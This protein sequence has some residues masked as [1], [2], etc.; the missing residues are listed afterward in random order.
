MAN[1]FLP[2]QSQPQPNR[3][4]LFDDPYAPLRLPPLAQISEF[5]RRYDRLADIH[6]KKLTTNL[7][8]NLDVLLIFA[9]L[10]SAI[11]TTFISIT[12]PDLSPNPS[13]ETNALLRLLVTRADNN[14][15]TQSDFAPPFSAN[16]NSITV[17]CLLY[18]SLSCSLL[19]AV[20]AMMA[21]E[22]LQSFDRTGQTGPLEDQARFRQR[23]YNGVQEWHLEAV[24]KFLPNLLLLSVIFF[25]VGICL[26]LFPIN[27]IVAG[28][29]I[30][31]SGIG[32]V[33]SGIVIVAG[34]VSLTCPYQSAASNALRRGCRGLVQP[35]RLVWRALIRPAV[36]RTSEEL[37]KVRTNM[38]LWI[39]FL[40]AK[41]TSV[42]LRVRSWY[43]RSLG[44]DHS[45]G[46]EIIDQAPARSP[47]FVSHL[48]GS[49]R[50]YFSA[51]LPVN[52]D[53]EQAENQDSSNEAERRTI[54]GGVS[55]A[56]ARV[57]RLWEMLPKMGFPS[58]LHQDLAV[59]PMK[60]NGDQVLT[61]QAA[62]WLLE[63]TSNRGDQ[64]STGQFICS[65]DK[66]TCANIFEEHDSWNR[67]F[68]LTLGSF[69]IWYS[70]PNKENQEVAELFG[71]V[72]CRVL[73]QC[74]KEDAKWSDITGNSLQGS[75]DF[76]KTFLHTLVPASTRYWPDDPEDD[77][78]ILY[79]SLMFTALKEGLTLKEFQ[80]A[81][82]S[83]LLD[84]D[85]PAAAALLRVWTLIVW[86]VGAA[87][88][89]MPV[90]MYFDFTGFL[91]NEGELAK[92]LSG[93]LSESP[94]CFQLVQGDL[95]SGQHAAQGY[96]VCLQKARQL[97]PKPVLLEWKGIDGLGQLIWSYIDQLA[98]SGSTEIRF[99]K[100]SVEA[101]LT[102]RTSLSSGPSSSGT[103][104]T[105][106]NELISSAALID[107][108]ADVLI[109]ELTSLTS[110]D[111]AWKSKGRTF[112]ACI[113][114]MLL[115]IWRNHPDR[116]PWRWERREFFAS[117]CRLWAPLEKEVSFSKT[118]S[119][120][121]E[122]KP[123][124]PDD[125][126]GVAEFAQW[127][128]TQNREPY[129]NKDWELE[130]IKTS[131]FI[132]LGADVGIN[133]LYAHF[134]RR[135]D[136]KYHLYDFHGEVPLCSRSIYTE[137]DGML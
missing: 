25:F 53:S 1:V 77:Q 93:A 103:P 46:Q 30:A 55:K 37:R 104:S 38:R 26:F 43:R 108:V 49:I 39:D 52:V 109:D 95:E 41:A 8:G 128:Q 50:V 67:L 85:T 54:G 66:A 131:N 110:L 71:L 130:R 107:T 11:N 133:R 31:F 123:L 116:N 48:Y 78:R 125:L 62:R 102:L 94:Q 10:F 6:D 134:D 99:V 88:S 136:W 58:T 5:W 122:D 60:A 47:H 29:V 21:K 120:G 84:S 56:I 101:L 63:T 89:G 23:K 36:S 33:F 20:G 79:T 15:L 96:T 28:I 17:N 75:S 72:L 14:T 7:N 121:D 59:A 137:D 2:H 98:T 118:G 65:L 82:P 18:A 127:V 119:F 22:W 73:L 113:I 117:S 76:V 34:A 91:E 92:N 115:W 12:M 87:Q 106:R 4:Y 27:T 24:I 70:Q 74:P 124:T 97:S 135:V 16:S 112:K 126:K 86:G 129:Y 44:L 69:E 3:E 51:W 83:R 81:N 32:A 35:C 68:N 45:L 90:G 105:S 114:R 42:I 132:V 13:D 57:K 64:I 40:G 9:A 19:A 61:I 111:D 80:W 100:L